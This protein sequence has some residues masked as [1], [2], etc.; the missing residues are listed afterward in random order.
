MQD[1]AEQLQNPSILLD[2]HNISLLIERIRNLPEECALWLKMGSPARLIPRY[3]SDGI[4]TSDLVFIFDIN[5]SPSK[6]RR[7]I[8]AIPAGCVFTPDHDIP[9]AFLQVV[10]PALSDGTFFRPASQTPIINIEVVQQILPEG[11][12]YLSIIKRLERKPYSFFS[13]PEPLSEANSPSVFR[14]L[15]DF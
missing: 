6:L 3:T 2:A 7:I 9:I 8:S 5:T 15:M 11:C 1:K 14:D 12:Q 13:S 10:C 4:E